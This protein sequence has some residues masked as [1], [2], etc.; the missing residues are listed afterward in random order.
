MEFLILLLLGGLAAGVGVWA[1]RGDQ[2]P[3]SGGGASG[4]GGAPGEASQ[5]S[6]KVGRR[7][8]DII[9][10]DE[11]EIE[12]PLPPDEE[13]QGPYSG[14]P[15]SARKQKEQR[16]PPAP[17]RDHLKLPYKTDSIIPRD[18]A[19][20]HHR[21][22]LQNAESMAM[23][24]RLEEAIRLFEKVEERIPEEEIKSK[25]RENIQSMQDF[26][27][28][29]SPGEDEPPSRSAVSPEGIDSI[30]LEK[31][32]EGLKAIAEGLMNQIQH[33][34]YIVPGQEGEVPAGATPVQA[35]QVPGSTVS[36]AGV[37]PQ[38][39]I[40]RIESILRSPPPM[41]GEG[42]R[43]GVD[44]KFRDAGI[45]GNTL[46]GFTINE[47]GEVVTRG[48]TDSDF[49]R[50]WEKFKNLPLKD[51]RSGEDRR[52][53]QSEEETDLYR[54]RR[55]EG[56]R[57]QKDLF[58]ER[59]EYLG[60]LEEHKRNK[61]IYEEYQK[62]QE[63]ARDVDDEAVSLMVPG[64]PPPRKEKE[65]RV[66]SES[67]FS[68]RDPFLMM[69]VAE[70]ALRIEGEGIL[71]EEEEEDS[72]ELEGEGEF[73]EDSSIA[74]LPLPDPMEEELP[75]LPPPIL[76]EGYEEQATPLEPEIPEVP[77][78]ISF[79]P[80]GHDITEPLEAPGEKELPPIP[81]SFLPESL[82]AEEEP[83]PVREEDEPYRPVQFQEESEEP[84][85]IEAGSIR[86]EEALQPEGPEE[87][88]DVEESSPAYSLVSSP[89]EL[90]PLS[91]PDPMEDQ[92]PLFTPGEEGET[93]F[94]PSDDEEDDEIETPEIEPIEEEE[95][96]PPVQEIRG[97]LELKPPDED[98]APYLT[99]TYDFSKIPDSFKL[100][101]D[102]HTMEYAYYKYK[103]MLIKAR[104]FTRRK[105]LKNALNYYR[106]I[107][108]QNI[109]PEFRK[110]INRNIQDITDY[111]EKYLMGR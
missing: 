63:E 11:D 95:A 101:Q 84:L 13:S 31:L 58:Q 36:M 49:D 103:P 46:T 3:A 73:E 110:M 27:D 94:G 54:D 5:A 35:A 25:I 90:D 111:L 66:E 93:G 2:K 69:D 72:G 44:W 104:E 1:T 74:E 53:N 75:A 57:R 7:A 29:V 12:S 16:K 43:P 108:S 106:V 107:K 38:G 52:Q 47:E 23:N 62:M 15:P 77:R 18:S 70:P 48:M 42:V 98:D 60:L 100:S 89:A 83:E 22:M 61:K 88:E 24:D 34:F 10:I 105:M 97:V 67:I 86:I 59:E 28:G 56:D 85:Y 96:P 14:P 6:P 78:P 92:D 79:L 32:A 50:E 39:G 9:A 41:E 37:P 19:Y 8:G 65:I 109:P 71:D 102:Y 20:S 76:P 55:A 17:A 99:L 40:Q 80:E 68:D 81:P 4:G 26:L 30:A 51:R 21:R 87:E 33:S 91:L 64:A 82:D 45:Q